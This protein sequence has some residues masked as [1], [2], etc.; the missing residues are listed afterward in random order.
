VAFENTVVTPGGRVR[1]GG[2]LGFGRTKG[3]PARNGVGHRARKAT[4]PDLFV[5]PRTNHTDSIRRILGASTNS[6]CR[7]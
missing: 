4:M 7:E 1:S 3:L 5:P 2:R 6:P